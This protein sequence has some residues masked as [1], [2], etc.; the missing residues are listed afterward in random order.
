M[1]LVDRQSAVQTVSPQVNGT[2]VEHYRFDFQQ[3]QTLIYPPTVPE[4]LRVLSSSVDYPFHRYSGRHVKLATCNN[5]ML[6]ITARGLLA[7]TPYTRLRG[8]LVMRTEGSTV[9]DSGA[10]LLPWQWWSVRYF[11]IVTNAHKLKIRWAEVP[12]CLPSAS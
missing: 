5:L 9:V 6:K 3:G 4:G 10:G 11:L 1:S 8:L 2:R 12:L 7:F